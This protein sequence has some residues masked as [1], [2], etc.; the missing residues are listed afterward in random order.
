[1]L[2]ADRT[3]K[4]L[5]LSLRKGPKFKVQIISPAAERRQRFIIVESKLEIYHCGRFNP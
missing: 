5:L 4:L 3:N 2:S 1:M